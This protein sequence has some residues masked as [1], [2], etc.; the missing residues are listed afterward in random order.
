MTMKI[1]IVPLLW[2]FVRLMKTQTRAAAALGVSRQTFNYWLNWAQDV[3]HDDQ[4]KMRHLLREAL[5]KQ[6]N[7]VLL[8]Q[9]DV[10]DP[11]RIADHFL[12]LSDRGRIGMGYVSQCG[13][14]QGKRS[15][16][17]PKIA[18][19]PLSLNDYFSTAE[20][21]KKGS[22][23]DEIGDYPLS[24]CGKFHRVT[25]RIDPLSGRTDQL[26][27]D[28]AGL[29]SVYQFRFVRNV[30]RYGIAKLTDA[31]D[32][33]KLSPSLA[34]KMSFFPAAIQAELLQKNPKDRRAYVEK[35]KIPPLAGNP[36]KIK[37]IK[38]VKKETVDIL[39]D[40][41]F[42]TIQN[43]LYHDAELLAAEHCHHL[44]FRTALSG[45][46][47][48]SDV[49]GRFRWD[50]ALLEAEIFPYAGWDFNKLFCLLQQWGFILQ[51]TENST[52]YGRVLSCPRHRKGGV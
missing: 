44:P 40:A 43:V 38:T 6:G 49:R 10:S 23:V 45:L 15:D 26:A 20:G 11:V 17:A 14:R 12:T 25:G 41:A 4:E 18:H 8:A 31:M 28:F 7:K 22:F 39:D 5:K 32:S 1:E 34:S 51:E 29:S 2:A 13:S 21:K 16:L 19:E 37:E 9:G 52:L 27:A 35:N 47:L 50:I 33:K 48:Y 24:L 46:L 36:I 30:I 3:P 42:R